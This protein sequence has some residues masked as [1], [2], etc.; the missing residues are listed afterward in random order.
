MC[1]QLRKEFFHISSV[2][3]SAFSYHFLS[4]YFPY[5]FYVLFLK[6]TLKLLLIFF[7]VGCECVR[8]TCHP[9]CVLLTRTAM[10]QTHETGRTSSP[11]LHATP[12]SCRFLLQDCSLSLLPLR[13]IKLCTITHAPRFRVAVEC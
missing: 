9:E 3:L 1:S 10:P 7:F 2:S 13:L 8:S 6:S 4:Y 11:G 12:S 5:Y